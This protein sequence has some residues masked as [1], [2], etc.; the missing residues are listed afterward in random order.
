MSTLF[1][2]DDYPR[3]AWLADAG[4]TVAL[5]LLIDEGGKVASCMVIQPSGLASLDAQSCAII[6]VRAK[7]DPALGVDG[8]PTKSGIT[9]RIKW[10]MQ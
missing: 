10:M 1:G 8:R 6:M 7:F 4:G 2:S 9:T 5:T 3:V